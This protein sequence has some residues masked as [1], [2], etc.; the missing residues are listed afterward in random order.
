MDIEMLFYKQG[1]KISSVYPILNEKEF[2]RNNSVQNT[3]FTRLLSINDKQK[4]INWQNPIP[5]KSVLNLKME[6]TILNQ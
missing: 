6:K 2:K 1:P 5:D 3:L 4:D